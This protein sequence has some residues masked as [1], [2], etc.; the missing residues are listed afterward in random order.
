MAAEVVDRYQYRPPY[1]DKLYELLLSQA[2]AHQRLL[3]LGAGPGKIARHLAPHFQQV[4]AID[5]STDMIALGRSLI[6][7]ERPNIDWVAG[8]AED[9]ALDG[10]YDMVVAALSIHWMDHARLFTRL[11]RHLNPAHVL[12]V[13]EGDGPHDPPWQNDWERFLVKCV[14]LMTGAPFEPGQHPEFWT[15]YQQYVEIEDTVELISEP[16]HQSVDEFILC[17]H[18]RD[19]FTISKLGARRA[20][21]DAELRELLFA[22]ADADEQLCFST[23]TTLT[24]AKI[25]IVA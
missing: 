7:G 2:P 5:P 25:P 4:T 20:E 23:I 11:T 19:T 6:H 13:I 10:S 9:A 8:Y 17:Q 15:R 22:Y 18:S 24:T 1:P 14:P 3:D 12:A 21:F 16:I